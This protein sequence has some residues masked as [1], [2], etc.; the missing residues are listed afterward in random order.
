[1]EEK[2]LWQ[3]LRDVQERQAIL[4]RAYSLLRQSIHKLQGEGI[5]A[6]DLSNAFVHHPEA[7]YKDDCC[8]INSRGNEVIGQRLLSILRELSKSSR[9]FPLARSNPLLSKW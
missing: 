7:L 3:N 6:M 8:H 5:R 2:K 4:T 1:V 9:S